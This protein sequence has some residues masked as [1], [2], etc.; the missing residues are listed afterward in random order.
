[1]RGALQVTYR[2]GKGPLAGA[3][4]SAATHTS[5]DP[6]DA[7]DPERGMSPNTNRLVPTATAL[8]ASAME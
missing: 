2:V 8:W 7:G 3:R 6:P 1:M 5:T 4:S